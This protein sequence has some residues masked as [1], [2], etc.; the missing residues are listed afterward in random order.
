MA[1]KGGYKLNGTQIAIPHGP[2][3][4]APFA[5]PGNKGTIQMTGDHIEMPRMP[6]QQSPSANPKEG[7]RQNAQASK[8]PMSRTPVKLISDLNP[9]TLP[10]SERAHKQSETA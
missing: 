7:M 2:A 9:G 10:F 8:E 3:T 1:E 5:N 6:T 4:G